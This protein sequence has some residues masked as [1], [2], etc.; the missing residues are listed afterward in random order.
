MLFFFP[1][2]LIQLLINAIAHIGIDSFQLSLFLIISYN[3]RT[4]RVVLIRQNGLWD[5]SYPS[6]SHGHN[7]YRRRLNKTLFW[8]MGQEL[9][10]RCWVWVLHCHLNLQLYPAHGGLLKW[11]A[12]ISKGGHWATNATKY[13]FPL[14]K[15]L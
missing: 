2:F 1:L 7:N 13:S 6:Q 5:F 10:V 3:S 12:I 9:E 8:C 15:G 11:Q 4:M 14:N